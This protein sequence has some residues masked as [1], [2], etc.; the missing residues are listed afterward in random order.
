MF[1]A[2][3]QYSLMLV[4]SN[5]SDVIDLTWQEWLTI[6]SR[7]R[8]GKSVQQV[9]TAWKILHQSIYNCTD[10]IAVCLFC[11]SNSHMFRQF[12]ISKMLLFIH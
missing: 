10:G 7:R 8:Y 5:V 4:F 3:L 6:Y 2:V 1:G 11:P 9:E 12:F